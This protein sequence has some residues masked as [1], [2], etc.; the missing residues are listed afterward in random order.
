MDEQ[1]KERCEVKGDRTAAASVDEYIAG[2][3]PEVREILEQ[4][5]T[6]IRNAAPDA[7][8]AI[9]YQIPAYRLNG[10]PV[11]YFAGFRKHVGVYPAPVGNPEF[12]G[13]LSAYAAGKGTVRFPLDKPIPFD[14]ITEIVKFRIEENSA[15]A[16]EKRKK[17]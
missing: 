4:T 1:R 3:P 12:E 13:N 11:V 9:S 17:T 14:L 7:E 5:R 2:F 16:A 10:S 15:R 6:T 8:E